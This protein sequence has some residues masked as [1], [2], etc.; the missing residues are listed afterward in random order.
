MGKGGF[1]QVFVGRRV[2]GGTDRLSGLGTMEV[3][4]K[5]EH[6]NN[7]GYSYGPPYEW[8]VYKLWTCLDLVYGMYGILQDNSD[9]M[10]DDSRKSPVYVISAARH[11]NAGSKC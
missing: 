7:K 1:G 4:L 10:K 8:Q 9:L 6:R 3:A 5:F 11:S 2:S